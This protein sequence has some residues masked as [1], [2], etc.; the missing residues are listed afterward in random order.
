VPRRSTIRRLLPSKSPTVQ[1]TC[2]TAT[3]TCELIDSTDPG[4]KRLLHAGRRRPVTH[5]SHSVGRAARCGRRGQPVPAPR[6]PLRA[7]RQRRRRG[8]ERLAAAVLLLAR[9]E[10]LVAAAPLYAK[11][12]SYGEYVF[13]WAW[14]EAYQRHGLAYYPK[15]LV[16]VPFTPVPGTRCW[17]AT[18]TPLGAG[19]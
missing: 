16:A 14:A 7:D 18:S 8:A 2:A 9:G 3:L 11:D 19:R 17:R 13:D 15:W 12:H 6:V 4:G 10:E 5:R 1:L